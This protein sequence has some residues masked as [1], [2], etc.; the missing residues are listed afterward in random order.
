[1]NGFG[2]KG[3]FMT[4]SSREL[5]DS[6]DSRFEREYRKLNTEQRNAVSHVNGPALILAGPGSGKTTV[7]TA[8]AAYLINKVN[9]NPKNI[10]TL[11]FNKAAQLEMEKRFYRLYGN[12]SSEKVH[13]STLHSFCN[14]VV[15]DYERLKGRKLKRIEGNDQNISK[16]QLLKDIYFNINSSRINDD[17]L[18]NLLNEIGLVK[19]SLIKEFEGMSFN[20]KKFPQIYKAYDD[21]KKSNLLMDFD[22]MLTYSYS[23]LTRYPEILKSYR[24][25]YNFI[26]VDEGQDLSKIQYEIIKLLSEESRNIFIVADDDQS[27]YGFRGAQPGYI[28][29]FEKQYRDCRIFRLQNNY[30]STKNIVKLSSSFIM[31]NKSRYSKIHVTGNELAR[32]PEILKAPDQRGQLE[33]V[34]DKLNTMIQD[35]GNAGKGNRKQAAVLYRNNLSSILI[36]DILDRNQLPFRIR[37]NK[38]YFFKHWLVQEVMAFLLFALDPRDVVAFSKIYYRMNRY[39]SRAMLECAMAGNGGRPVID[40]IM[41]GVELK[42]FQINALQELKLE[43]SSL[44]KKRPYMALE[45]IKNNF[46][47]LD[48][49]KEYCTLTGIS[50][51]YLCRL[52][53]I[54]SGIAYNCQ[55]LVEFLDRLKE[56]DNLFEGEK[57]MKPE[58]ELDIT[59][60]TIHSSKGLEYD[61][62]I[63]IDLINN[64]IPGDKTLEKAAESK[65]M[66]ALEE[67]RRLFYVGITRARQELYLVYPAMVNHEKLLPSLF[68]KEVNQLLK[69]DLTSGI[70]EGAIVKHAKFGRGVIVSMDTIG[71]ASAASGVVEI[72]FFDGVVRKLDL[73]LCLDNGMI[74]LEQMK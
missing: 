61:S 53:D 33:F 25:R 30:R 48:G 41:N 56:L 59:L 14:R 73:R 27:I 47:Y 31:K 36:A 60:S 65:D 6:S 2:R 43:F 21:Y 5:C 18:E 7:I 39:I 17:E 67:E 46:K 22:D 28:L 8:R 50:Y 20:T 54:L 62:V 57:S 51:E 4:Q 1:M 40:C 45:Y 38:L 44:S 58:A 37:Q 69:N 13:F 52:F 9:V 10:L 49:I 64:E 35:R 70:G 42:P 34:L 29:N 16:H 19:N 3:I 74:A 11:T 55:T 72:K 71:Q 26:Q 63:I 66:S 23:I 12:E 32:D 15:R 68:I 24:N